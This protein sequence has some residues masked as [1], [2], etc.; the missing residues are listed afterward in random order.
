MTQQLLLVRNKRVLPPFIYLLTSQLPE[1]PFS[2]A[3]PLND[4][5]LLV[6]E[7]FVSVNPRQ[8][9]A[10][11]KLAILRGEM[12][13]PRHVNRLHF[14]PKTWAIIILI[15]SLAASAF[16]GWRGLFSATWVLLGLLWLRHCFIARI[17]G[18]TGD[19]LGAAIE[20][21]EAVALLGFVCVAYYL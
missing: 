16:W 11:K 13:E 3:R 1:G 21:S 7:A 9:R 5:S 19:T 2:R 6:R 12:P 14:L 8:G 4:N 18:V 15:S 10:T 17:G 20:V